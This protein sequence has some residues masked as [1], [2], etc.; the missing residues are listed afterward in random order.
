MSQSVWRQTYS[1]LWVCRHVNINS[2]I[3]FGKQQE[4]QFPKYLQITCSTRVDTP[5]IKHRTTH[6][7][8]CT[9]SVSEPTLD[10]IYLL[11]RL[12]LLRVETVEQQGQEQVQHHKVAHDECRQEDGKARRRPILPL[13]P[14]AVPQWLNPLPAQDPEYHHEGVEE[15]VEIPSES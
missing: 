9:K 4:L 2:N 12:E 14:H 7:C 5:S 11:L 10:L 3:D 13:C 6:Q 1:A 15:V 8:T